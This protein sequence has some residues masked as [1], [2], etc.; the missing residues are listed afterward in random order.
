MSLFYLDKKMFGEK[1]RVV[2]EHGGMRAI[3]FMY[4]TGSCALRIENARGSFT[5]LP[6][7]G[8]QIWRADFDGIDLQMVTEI[9]EPREGNDFC[10]SYGCMMMHSG[11]CGVGGPGPED[12]HKVHGDLPVAPFTDPRIE[13][14]EDA[15]GKFITVIGTYHHYRTFNVNYVFTSSYKLYEHGTIISVTVNIENLRR[16]PLEYGY[17]CHINFRPFEGSKLLCTAPC[18]EKH[19]RVHKNIPA[20]M[21]E[22]DAR[23]LSDYMDAM[24]K[25]PEVQATVDKAS[26]MYDPEIVST[27]FYKGDEDGNAHTM[28]LRPDG[29]AC[30]VKHPIEPLNYSLR[31]ISRTENEDC[32]GMVLPA[33]TEHKGYSHAKREGQIRTIEGGKSVNFTVEFGLLVP[34]E[35]EK[36]AEKIERVLR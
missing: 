3:T 35:A 12:N 34:C 26:Q 16:T 23:A 4:T 17:L 21:P 9:E 25:T 11:L 13:T 1:E 27:L 14:G 18:D 7:W 36:M 30:Y 6:Y 24:Q 22:K 33:S 32:M 20:S 31:W 10:D 28:Q 8:H 5:V 15:N 2:A 29:Y 19:I